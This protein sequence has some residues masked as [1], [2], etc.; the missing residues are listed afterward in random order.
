VK[1]EPKKTLSV[2]PYSSGIKWYDEDNKIILEAM[3]RGLI[4]GVRL[5]MAQVVRMLVRKTDLNTFTIEDYQQ[6]ATADDG[7][8]SENKT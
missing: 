1:K 2:A 7:R 3:Q 8:R 5:N 6:A 4:F